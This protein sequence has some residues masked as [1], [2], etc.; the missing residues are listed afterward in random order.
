MTATEG[1]VA[2][3]AE[4]AAGKRKFTFPT[5]FTILFGLLILV[6]IAT[7]IIPAGTYALSEDG[8][9]VGRA[10]F[11]FDERAERIDEV[12][13]LRTTSRATAVELKGCTAG[14]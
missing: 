1:A 6:A 12:V 8:A 14:G 2:G 11:R 4:P 9:E 7:W 13:S 3:T 10:D 5:A